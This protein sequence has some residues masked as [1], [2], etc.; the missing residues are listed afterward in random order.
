MLINLLHEASGRSLGVLVGMLVGTLITAYIARRRQMRERQRILDGDARDTVVIHQHILDSVA[1]V[2][3]SG[4]TRT[5][6]VL[7]VRTLGQSELNRVVPNGHL[8]GILT[9]CAHGHFPYAVAR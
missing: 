3:S 1:Q 9:E 4:V 7:R 2:D 6:K 8:A 5:V